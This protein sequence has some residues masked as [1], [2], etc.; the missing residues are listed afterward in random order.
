MLPKSVLARLDDILEAAEVARHCTSTTTQKIG[1]DNKATRYVPER[2]LE[3]ASD[4]VRHI[5]DALQSRYPEIPWRSIKTIGNILRHEYDRV[6]FDVIWDAAT[7]H[8]PK[9]ETA[10]Q[11]M[12]AE[13]ENESPQ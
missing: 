5:P 10:I 12:R 9:L 8:L 1:E 7:V 13:L 2:S 4:A 3:I 6:D 11:H